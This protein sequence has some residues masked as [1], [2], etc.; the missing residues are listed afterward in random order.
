MDDYSGSPH[1]HSPDE[2][3]EDQLAAWCC[4]VTRDLSCWLAR[5]YPNS[6]SEDL[7]SESLLRLWSGPR[8]CLLGTSQGRQVLFRIGRNMA[9]DQ[10]RRAARGSGETLL[11]DGVDAVSALVP[12]EGCRDELRRSLAVFW[13]ILGPML[14]KTERKI[15]RC[16]RHGVLANETIATALGIGVRAVQKARASLMAKGYVAIQLTTRTKSCSPEAMYGRERSDDVSCLYSP[17]SS[18]RSLTTEAL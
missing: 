3:A 16:A 18:S 10:I 9:V 4:R 6:W 12:A 8:R 14:G 1:Q 15:V 11:G 5:R 17:E 13:R 2:R 7:A